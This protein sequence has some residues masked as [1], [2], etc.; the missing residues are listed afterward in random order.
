MISP[1]I[2][3]TCAHVAVAR[4]HD[5]KH[6]LY[7]FKAARAFVNDIEAKPISLGETMPI[8][9][10]IALL[11]TTMPIVSE[12]LCFDIKYT[13]PDLYTVRPSKFAGA[14]IVI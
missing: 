14:D 13:N 3:V 11:Q 6:P 5:P 10:D 8:H 4:P 1:T 2:V 9:Y 7:H 12:E